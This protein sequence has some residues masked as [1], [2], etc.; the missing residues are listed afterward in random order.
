MEMNSEFIPKMQALVFSRNDNSILKSLLNKHYPQLEV[1]TITAEQL[2]LLPDINTPTILF[3]DTDHSENSLLHFMNYNNRDELRIIFTA[4][5][6]DFAMHAFRLSAI[7]YLL[8]PIREHD[9]HRAVYR[10]MRLPQVQ[11]ET[12][13]TTLL[14]K[15]YKLALPVFN[16]ISFITIGD[17]LYCESSNNYTYF[18]MRTGERILV[19]RT[20]KEFEEQ[21]SQHSFFRIHQKYLVNLCFV[22]HYVRGRGGYVVMEN[23]AELPVAARKKDI[24]LQIVGSI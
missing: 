1:S 7:D 11:P 8:K 4:I 2:D 15:R 5:N 10:A 24:F 20:L 12:N 6:E 9:L 14:V 13:H 21:L 22:N 3:L 16:G 18:Y 19:S 23:S 17:I